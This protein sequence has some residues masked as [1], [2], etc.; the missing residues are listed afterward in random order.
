MRPLDKVIKAIKLLLPEE[1][2]GKGDLVYELDSITESVNFS[3]P[4][5]LGRCWTRLI[6]A[7]NDHLGEIDTPWKQKVAD[8]LST[9]T[10][11]RTVLGE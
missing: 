7:M 6:E 5:N 3:A 10:D 9:K 11:Y 1:F 8:V 4:E 2:D